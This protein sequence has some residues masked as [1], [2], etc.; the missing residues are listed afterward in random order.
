M[1]TVNKNL[2]AAFSLSMLADGGPFSRF[3]DPKIEKID[4]SRKLKK[5]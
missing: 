3:M 5:N 1:E 2:L 4:F